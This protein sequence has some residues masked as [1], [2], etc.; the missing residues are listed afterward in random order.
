MTV[1]GTGVMSELT[2]EDSPPDNVDSTIDDLLRSHNPSL[3]LR[4]MPS[5][6]IPHLAREAQLRLSQEMQD[7][8]VETA[9]QLEDLVPARRVRD[10]RMARVVDA[11][12]GRKERAR[13]GMVNVWEARALDGLLQEGRRYLVSWCLDLES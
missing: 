11:R 8:Q 5:G 1:S 7:A 9:A 2:R 4:S 3:A 10:F 6:H 13:V 12:E